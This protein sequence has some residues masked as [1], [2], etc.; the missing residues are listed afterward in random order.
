MMMPVVVPTMS[1]MR[2]RH[3]L[4]FDGGYSG[5]DVQPGLALHADGLQRVGI[6]RTTDQKVAAETQP[7]RGVDADATVIARE[8]AAADPVGRRSHRPGQLGLVG[9]TEIDANP[10]D[11]RDV[12]FGT[13]ALALEH[14]FEAG[15]RAHHEAD[16][17]AALA[18]QDT[19][20]ILRLRHRVGACERRS[21]RG[22]GD[23]KCR[24]S[25]YSDLRE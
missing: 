16:I 9:D 14:T 3:R 21:E 5:R 15:R 7:D 17:L 1:A 23:T 6:G 22:D 20:L 11:G 4:D 19:R 10:A 18:L 13:L 12:R 2:E 24:K 25:H 8:I